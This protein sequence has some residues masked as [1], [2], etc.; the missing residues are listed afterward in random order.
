MAYNPPEP[1][2]LYK[3]LGVK[4]T[5]TPA[6]IKKAF[7][8]MSLRSHPDKAGNTP[9]NNEKFYEIK[10][11]YDVLIDEESRNGYD[12]YQARNAPQR[13]SECSGSKSNSRSSDHNHREVPAHHS[14]REDPRRHARHRSFSTRPSTR[15][16][17]VEEQPRDSYRRRNS[18]YRY[19]DP[20]SD[21]YSSSR[22]Y[23]DPWVYLRTPRRESR[24]TNLNDIRLEAVKAT[25]R[26]IKPIGWEVQNNLRYLTV[27]HK[28]LFADFDAYGLNS[29]ADAEMFWELFESTRKAN[30]RIEGE[31]N[32][33]IAETRDVWDGTATRNCSDL[34]WRTCDVSCKILH[35]LSLS[36]ALRELSY[37]LSVNFRYSY[38]EVRSEMVWLFKMWRD[39]P[40]K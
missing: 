24:R 23:E 14:S 26:Q 34:P 13:D 10:E 40:K 6:E 15:E 38:P 18:S 1:K 12:A 35:M 2:D 17:Y 7:R 4:S 16:P 19:W 9:E 20:R 30:Y 32:E 33:I 31:W 22:R 21:S 36:S 25:L 8:E 5:A 3:I 39:T 29:G 37:I 11:A 27:N 28:A